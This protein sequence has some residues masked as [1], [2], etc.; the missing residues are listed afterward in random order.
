M[1]L[2]TSAL[3]ASAAIVQATVATA[4]TAVPVVVDRYVPA[5]W[6]MRDPV[7]ASIGYVRVE[8]PAN[9]A[10]FTASYEVVDR[11]APEATSKAADKV[12]ALGD[13]LRAMGADKVRIVT[14]FA[15]TP[16][17]EQYRDKN[18]NMI[19]NQRADKIERYQVRAE[20]SIEVRDTSL[21][22]QTYATVMAAKP[23]SASQVSFRLDPDNETK[24]ALYSLAVKDAARRA[25]LA[26]DNAGARLGAAKVIDPTARACQTDVLAGEASAPEGSPMQPTTVAADEVVVTGSRMRE[27][28][29]AYAPKPPPPPG[30]DISPETMKLPIQPPLEEMTAQSCVIYGLV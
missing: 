27:D 23:T 1:R 19:D 7:I 9:R 2:F 10:S 25:R 16:L 18:G 28:K 30:F 6:W 29:A 20:V 17:Y 13:A 4:Q 14:T 12:R 11:S 26:V 3:L 5:P 24:T 21:L 8:L 15:T 22:E